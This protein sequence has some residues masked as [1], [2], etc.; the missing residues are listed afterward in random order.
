[1]AP[2]FRI[3]ARD[4]SARAGVLR[5]GHGEVHTPAFVPLA[6]TATVKTLHASEVAALGFEMVLGNTF[7]LFIQPGH[8]HVREMGGLHEFMGWRR[9][10]ITD[11]GGYQVF[12]MGHGSVADEVKRRRDPRE[13]M[14]LAI[15]E[16]GVRFRSYLDGAER[17]MGPETSME[18]QAALDS[19]VAL[20]FDECT[21]F[22]VDRD[23]TRASM[24]R[25]HRWLD[26][27]VGWH[28]EHA[29]Q[30]Q[31]LFG[32]VQGGVHEDL[33]AESAA[34]VSAAEVDGIAVGGSL[35][36]DKDEMRQVVE[37]S[38]RRLPDERPRHLLGIG[39]VDDVLHAVGAG[40]DLFDCATPTRLARHG[41]ALVP[42]PESRWRLDLTRPDSRSSR[43]PM[44]AGCPCPACAEHTRGYLHYLARAHELTGA[45]LVTL[46]NLTFIATLMREIREAVAAGRYGAYAGRVL[47][48]QAPF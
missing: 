41:T 43:E 13:S 38:L 19:D 29:P 7:H 45:R 27:C 15:E 23:Y 2:T 46:H 48:G 24:E 8:E 20:A 4:G 44:V 34:Y 30:G 40:I 21:P 31:L 1:V 12:S 37:W 18:I 42:D 6:S 10:I 33:R 32:I 25:T 36:R 5:C 47:R 22:H 3:D 9:P 17:F 26:R 14:V 28:A 11:S 39:D 16:E 35:G